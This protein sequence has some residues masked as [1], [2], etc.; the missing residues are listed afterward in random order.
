LSKIERKYLGG[1]CSGPHCRLVVSRG[2]GMAGIPV[3]FRVCP[4]I[5]EITLVRA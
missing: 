4:E 2:V 5:G 3:R 1:F